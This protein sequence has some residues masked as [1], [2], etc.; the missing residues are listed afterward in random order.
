MSTY[1]VQADKFFLPAGV[2]G[3][4]YLMVEDGVFGTFTTKRPS[5]EVK[6]YTGCWIAPG[7][8]DTHIHGFLDHDVMDCDPE[9]IA[10]ISEGLT[11]CGVTSWTPTT[12]T[13]GVEQTG[14]ACA[15]VAEHLGEFEGAHIRGIFLEGPF[16]T[17]KHKG[18]Q[19]PAYF[20]DPDIEVFNQW[21]ARAHGL[22][23]K[24]AI[25]PERTGAEAFTAAV[26]RQ[27]VHVAL[28]HSDACLAE[29]LAC[30]NAGADVFIHAFN[31]M[32]PLH[33]REPGM[34][35]AAMV[36]HGSY[37]E[38]ICDGHHLHPQA[39]GALVNAKGSDYVVLITDCMRAG[40][41]PD[42]HYHLGEFPVI[43]ENGTARLEDSGNLAGSILKLNQ[44]IKN[45]YDWGLVKAEEAV[46]MATENAARANGIEATCGFIRPGFD[47]D[48]I[49]LDDQLNLRETYVSGKKVSDC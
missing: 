7:L 10:A 5:V 34:V 47:A 45:V 2:S 3:P 30:I 38:A 15:S 29:A 22:I 14:D 19:N 24:I 32:S 8:V 11:S 4:G 42:G 37:A 33:H 13:A 1:A 20:F 39:V 6:D 49:V 36:A 12:L 17:E 18:A 9:G 28:A 46:R 44:A 21:Q 25:A 35:G 43:V 16:F 27:G 23:K 40:G 48:F 26:S 41:M 31:G